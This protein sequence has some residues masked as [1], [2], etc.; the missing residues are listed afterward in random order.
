MTEVQY[1]DIYKPEAL[2]KNLMYWSQWT[3]W[4]K[5]VPIKWELGRQ[6][7]KK[8]KITSKCNFL[9][10]LRAGRSGR[11]EGWMDGKGDIH[12]T[13]ILAASILIIHTIHTFI[14]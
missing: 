13:L 11:G 3:L 7:K 14:M 6:T 2:P 10:Q 1:N 12:H 8:E 4:Q 5:E 9:G